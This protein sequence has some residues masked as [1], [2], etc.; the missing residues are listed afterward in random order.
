MP[1]AAS[2]TASKTA[3]RKAE[4]TV[5]RA[6]LFS[7]LRGYTSFVEA[8]GDAAAALLLREY[9]GLVRAAVARQ[10]GAEVK[11]E[12]DSFYVV[13][14]SALAALE[15]A[16]AIHRA[17]RAHNEAKP[18]API[19]IGLGLH[20]GETVPYDDQF[21]GGAVNVAARLAAKA[22]A[23]ELV[24]SDTFRGLIRTG[25][26][27]AM[28]DLGPQ[29]LK[30]VTERLRAWKVEWRAPSA[31]G[32]P[33]AAAVA[34]PALPLLSRS[35]P[36]GPRPV[37]GQLVCPVVVGR[38]TERARFAEHLGHAREG[39]GQTVLLSGEAGVGKSA[40]TRQAIETA[41][42]QGFRVLYGV[43][44]ESD[45]GLPYAPFVAAVRSGFRGI[46]RERL[47]RVLAQTAPD[48]AQLFPE[49]SKTSRS[50]A[51]SNVE[52]HRLSVAFQGLFSA[53]A[54][55]VRAITDKSTSAARREESTM[56][57]P[58]HFNAQERLSS[59]YGSGSV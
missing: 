58:S 40:F 47:G 33:P 10:G 11:T 48:L 52:Q 55:E 22:K 2:K 53:F 4:Q 41:T 1:R 18:D 8:R 39:R 14:E 21:V 30:G 38:T 19:Q 37:P 36:V 32:A 44:V 34:P 7:D 57:H 25:Q 26:G 29:R 9:R 20:V 6:F 24:V 17:A 59:G 23:G 51:A 12:G 54:R 3:S 43:T 49:L 50:E 28:E 27:Y 35:E 31:A 5:T 56:V 45:G 15:C 42:A 46:E 16:V 13:F